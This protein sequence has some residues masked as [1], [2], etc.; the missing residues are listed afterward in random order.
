M[1]ATAA[2]AARPKANG[3]PVS[4]RE[5]RIAE[6]RA[7]LPPITV[8]KLEEAS[9]LVERIAEEKQD[10]FLQKAADYREQHRQATDRPLKPDEAA[11]IAAALAET[12]SDDLLKDPGKTVASLQKSRLRAYDE[13]DPREVLLSAGL[14][15][16]PALIDAVK[17]LVALIELPAAEFEA[18]CESDTLDHALAEAGKVMRGV[19]LPDMRIRAT[20]ALEHFT[21]A[22]GVTPGEAWSLLV[23]MVGQA[24]IQAVTTASASSSLTGSLEPTDG[25]DDAS[26]TTPPGETPASS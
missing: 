3:R 10:L 25:P 2:K 4:D 9:K 8:G 6:A 18:S 17:E 12:I 15:T 13:P 1:P 26:S 16:G 7:K 20:A 11:Q 24:L 14:A 5:Q 21:D 23:Q 22:A 19:E